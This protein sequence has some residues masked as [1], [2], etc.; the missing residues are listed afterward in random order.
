MINRKQ[1]SKTTSGFTLIEILVVISVLVIITALVVPRV[2]AVS[3]DRNIRETARV[4]GSALSSASQRAQTNGVAG[5]EFVRNTNFEDSTNF[6]AGG[7]A[8]T[9]MFTLRSIPDF[10]GD[11]DDDR[12]GVAPEIFNQRQVARVFIPT[13][14]E[15]DPLEPIFQIG[16]QIRFNHRATEYPILTTPTINGMGFLTFLIDDQGVYPYPPQTFPMFPAAWGNGTTYNL[17]LI[18][19]SEPTRP[20]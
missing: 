16:D 5:I 18:H 20:Y 8:C 14:L 4:V 1:N 10:T 2:R 11:D 12:A 3:K 9:Q 13:P 15:H 7:F 19:I 17:S 6:A